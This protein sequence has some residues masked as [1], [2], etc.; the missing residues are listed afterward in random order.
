MEK[1]KATA[2]FKWFFI[3]LFS[4]EAVF[5]LII[6]VFG[7]FRISVADIYN[8]DKLALPLIYFLFFLSLIVSTFFVLYFRARYPQKDQTKFFLIGTGIIFIFCLLQSVTILAL[9]MEDRVAA[10]LDVSYGD[11]S[12]NLAILSLIPISLFVFPLI[13]SISFLFPPVFALGMYIFHILSIFFSLVDSWS[14]A[15]LIMAPLYVLWNFISYFVLIY[16]VRFI[17]RLPKQILWILALFVLT[18]IAYISFS[19]W[20]YKLVQSP[21][22][23]ENREKERIE[24]CEE[25]Y[26]RDYPR[27]EE[28]PLMGQDVGF[29]N[30]ISKSTVASILKKGDFT[31]EYIVVIDPETNNEIYIFLGGNPLSTKSSLRKYIPFDESVVT[32]SIKDSTAAWY[33]TSISADKPVY[34]E[35]RS[36]LA[37]LLDQDSPIIT[38][39]QF[40]RYMLDGRVTNWLDLYKFYEEYDYEKGMIA[41]SH[42]YGVPRNYSECYDVLAK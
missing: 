30:P 39:I 28:K 22:E 20:F 12:D 33:S 3:A 8:Y 23:E 29:I 11:K 42:Y 35:D 25:K 34:S 36:R 7:L 32:S 40:G 16:F 41:D 27:T 4:V 15:G 13:K 31:L 14:K 37:T 6:T 9:P 2:S 17:L 26:S 24:R 5:L 1:K 19:F 10:S 38:K 21:K 18:I